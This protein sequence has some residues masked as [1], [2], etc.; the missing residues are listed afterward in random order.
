MS[1]SIGVNGGKNDIQVANPLVGSIKTGMK[2]NIGK[3]TG[4][5]A[6]NVRFCA[7]LG[8]LQVEPKAANQDPTMMISR[9][10]KAKNQGIT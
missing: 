3:N 10:K 5:I 4:N 7:S 6:G 2:T 1:I 9:T 8:S